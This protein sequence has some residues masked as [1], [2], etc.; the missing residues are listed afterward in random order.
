MHKLV[1][2][3]IYIMFNLQ[4]TCWLNQGNKA[5]YET[6]M[7]NPADSDLRVVGKYQRAILTWNPFKMELLNPFIQSRRNPITRSDIIQ[8]NKSSVSSKSMK[9]CWHREWIKLMGT[10]GEKECVNKPPCLPSREVCDSILGC[11]HISYP[12]NLSKQMS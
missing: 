9:A 7:C 10:Y 8:H 3:K 6:W 4:W 5:I 12:L 2:L 1:I 11:K